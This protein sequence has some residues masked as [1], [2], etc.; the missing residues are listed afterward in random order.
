MSEQIYKAVLADRSTGGTDKLVL[1]ILADYAERDGS[2]YGSA[3]KV[4]EVAGISQRAAWSCLKRLQD[5]GQIKKTD[6]GGLDG[7][8]NPIAN[9]WQLNKIFVV[10]TQNL[11][12]EDGLATQNLRSNIP[13]VYKS[14]TGDVRGEQQAVNCEPLV[15]ISNTVASPPV[16]EEQKIIEFAPSENTVKRTPLDNSLPFQSAQFR[17]AWEMWAADRKYRRKPLTPGA[18]KLQFRKMKGFTETE[19]IAA[20]EEAIEKGW[21]SIFPR[22]EVQRYTAPA[23]PPKKSAGWDDALA[24][25]RAVC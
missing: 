12:K 17:E 25:A 11:H 2:C 24:M 20:I 19:C 21:Q 13:T 22:K 16:N 14:P 23:A 10:A 5:G 3:A 4:A 8:G 18:V 7:D 9:S 6:L 15:P 1:L